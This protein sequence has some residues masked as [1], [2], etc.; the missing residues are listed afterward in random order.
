[1]IAAVVPEAETEVKAED[2]DA[3]TAVATVALDAD[4]TLVKPE[5]VA[6]VTVLKKLSEPLE[7]AEVRNVPVEVVRDLTTEAVPDALAEASPEPVVDVIPVTTEVVVFPM[8]DTKLP[9]V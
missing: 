2:V 3:E 8:L 9:V 4:D 1:V 7:A 5:A 6:A